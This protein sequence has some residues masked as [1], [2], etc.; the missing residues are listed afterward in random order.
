MEFAITPFYHKN[1]AN[2]INLFSLR[3]FPLYKMVAVTVIP[4]TSAQN[5][6]RKYSTLLKK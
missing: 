5:F 4:R 6:V 1:F 3:A 2:D